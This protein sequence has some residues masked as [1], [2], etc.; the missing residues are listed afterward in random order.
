M[1]AVCSP[2]L[3]GVMGICNGQSHRALPGLHTTRSR[4]L[5]QK[6]APQPPSPSE[7]ESHSNVISRIIASFVKTAMVL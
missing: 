4:G 2:V 6:K 1:S 7:A 3:L 5:L